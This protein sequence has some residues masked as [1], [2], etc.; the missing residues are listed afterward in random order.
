[1]LAALIRSQ[2]AVKSWVGLF[3]GLSFRPQSLAPSTRNVTPETCS[4]ESRLLS[5]PPDT[6]RL[7]PETRPSAPS[8]HHPAPSAR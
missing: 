3:W 1:M 8:R 5:A 4:S 2:L 6:W 7:T